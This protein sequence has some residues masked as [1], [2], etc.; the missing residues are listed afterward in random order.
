M[1]AELFHVRTEV[2]TAILCEIEDAI[3]VTPEE[4]EAS[5]FTNARLY[6]PAVASLE[7][8]RLVS[9]DIKNKCASPL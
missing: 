7:L 4:A 8:V 9:I 3:W 1:K 6:D 5:R 2:E